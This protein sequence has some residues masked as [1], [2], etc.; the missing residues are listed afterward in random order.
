M[1][2][3]VFDFARWRHGYI[4]VRRPSIY[5]SEDDRVRPEVIR[6]HVTPPPLLYEAFG[7]DVERMIYS[8]NRLS[9]DAVRQT[10]QTRSRPALGARAVSRIHPWSE[11]RSLR[12]RGGRRIP[13]FSIR[14]SGR[15]GREQTIR[16]SIEV[17][18]FRRAHHKVRIAHRDGHREGRFP[19]GTYAMRT[20]HGAPVETTPSADAIVTQP[21]P[22]LCDVQARLRAQEG[23]DDARGRS[24]RLLEGVREQLEQDAESLDEHACMD[25]S[26]TRGRASGGGDADV[27]RAEVATRHRFDHDAQHDPTQQSGPAAARRLI[28]LR[29]RRM[30]RPTRQARHVADPPV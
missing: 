2:G 7:G 1:P 25:F 4:D 3:F 16:A 27:D 11:P 20:V 17:R 12:E 15:A 6:M 21:G 8:M 19:F 23:S 13:S 30:G 22:L 29:D 5:F 26:Q 24:I 28:I 18:E 10:K 9:D 14:A